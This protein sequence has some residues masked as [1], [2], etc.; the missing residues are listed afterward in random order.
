MNSVCLGGQGREELRESTTENCLV[1][2][3][4]LTGYDGRSR[5][6]AVSFQAPPQDPIRGVRAHPWALLGLTALC[7][8][9]LFRVEFP[10]CLLGFLVLTRSTPQEQASYVPPAAC[11]LHVHSSNQGN[12]STC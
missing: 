5:A 1:L 7:R 4:R 10:V 9:L 12:Q 8:C 6:W 2:N 3:R 11:F